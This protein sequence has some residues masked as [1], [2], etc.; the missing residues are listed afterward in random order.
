[1]PESRNAAREEAFWERYRQMVV[2]AGVEERLA[3]WYRRHVEQL[4]AF[5]KPRR[6]REATP[7]DIGEFLLRVHRQPDTE[8]WQEQQ[9]DKARRFTLSTN[10]E[11]AV[12]GGVVGATADRGGG[13]VCAVGGSGK[14]A[15]NGERGAEVQ[16]FRGCR[17]GRLR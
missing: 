5:L 7:A 4:I 11:D 8:V 3:V 14:R 12:G 10:R 17:C 16:G 1:M 13:G 6:L 2:D 15:G 9:A